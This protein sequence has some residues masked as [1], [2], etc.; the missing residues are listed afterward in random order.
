MLR[1]LGAWGRLV[2]ILTACWRGARGRCCGAGAPPPPFPRRFLPVASRLGGVR[3]DVRPPVAVVGKR[4]VWCSLW[5]QA[6]ARL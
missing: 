5:L 2:S 1:G 6:V 3:R 4:V